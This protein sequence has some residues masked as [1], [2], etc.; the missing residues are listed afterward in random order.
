MY[1]YIVSCL[2]LLLLCGVIFQ[3]KIK[4][5]QFLVYFIIIFGS[6]ISGTIVNGV[7]GLDASY[8]KI[9]CKDK[10]INT[11]YELSWIQTD[12]ISEDSICIDTL[13]HTTTLPIIYRLDRDTL[14][15]I[16][17]NYIYIDEIS[18]HFY[19]DDSIKNRL[20]IALVDD[21]IPR[22]RVYKYRRI[23]NN[24]WVSDFGLPS[25]RKRTYELDLP[26]TEET[27]T[28]MRMLN[29]NFYIDEEI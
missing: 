16:E 15:N 1:T 27:R 19:S 29:E 25:N 12:T 5:Y 24:N 17:R 3:K 26:D 8:S 10:I 4:E 11:S 23:S 14:G 21:S 18:L 13:L 28:L 9:L 2:L 6:M 20:T 7:L 22:I